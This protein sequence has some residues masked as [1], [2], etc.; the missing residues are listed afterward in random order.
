MHSGK[1]VF[2][3]VMDFL[4]LHSF[5]RCVSRYRGNHKVKRFSCFDQ[6]LCM[7]FAQLAQRE[8]VRDVETC[9]RAQHSKLYHMDLRSQVSRNTLA[10][11]NSRRDWRIYADFA[12]A[13]IRIARPLYSGIFSK[14][15]TLKNLQNCVERPRDIE[16]FLDDGD[17]HVDRYRDPNLSVYRVCEWPKKALI[18]RCCLIHL[19]NTSM[20][21]ALVS[22]TG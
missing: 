20:C 5:R 13:L 11:A 3:Q 12:Q 22:S 16:S 2:S 9:L 21:Q 6:Y 7:A 8:S 1:L 18:R 19:K 4:P 14:R 17:E 15:V 10:N